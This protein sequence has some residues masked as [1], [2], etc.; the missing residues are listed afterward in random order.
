MAK[1]GRK[2]GEPTKIIGFRVKKK[3]AERLK[4]LIKIIIKNEGD[5]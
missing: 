5:E 2:K 1:V 3:N 4:K